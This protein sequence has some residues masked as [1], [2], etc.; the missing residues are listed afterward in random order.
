MIW[1]NHNFGQFYRVLFHLPSTPRWFAFVCF[2]NEPSCVAT[3][4]PA[5]LRWS[6]G[7]AACG[8]AEVL[9]RQMS[10]TVSPSIGLLS[11]SLGSRHISRWLSEVS[12]LKP[13]PCCRPPAAGCFM[14]LGEVIAFKPALLSC[15]YIA[16]AIQTKIRGKVHS[17]TS[18][19]PTSKYCSSLHIH[20]IVKDSCT[21]LSLLFRSTFNKPNFKQ[22]N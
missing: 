2:G 6:C 4:R 17:Q 11:L 13:P 7:E 15:I 5:Q 14:L 20:I 18:E 8:E 10:V 16:I 21:D 3:S 1:N 9:W 19:W 12:S 22:Y